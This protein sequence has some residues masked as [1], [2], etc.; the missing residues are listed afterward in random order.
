MTRRVLSSFFPV[1]LL[2]ESFSSLLLPDSLGDYAGKRAPLRA[3]KL[4]NV[5]DLHRF[6]QKKSGS[7]PPGLSLFLPKI[8]EKE[9]RTV[10]NVHNRRIVINVSECEKQACFTGVGGRLRTVNSVLFQ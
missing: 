8:G 5:T 6:E 2:A 7:L 9:V 10:R 4:I 3:I 1:S